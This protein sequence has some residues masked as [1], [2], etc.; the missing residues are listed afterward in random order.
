MSSL[1]KRTFGWLGLAVAGVIAGPTP[2][3]HAQDW[4][5]QFGTSSHDWAYALAP[6]DAGGAILAGSTG[7]SLGGPNALSQLCQARYL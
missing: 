5:R 6:D 3:A 4:I 1:S 7:G 2:R